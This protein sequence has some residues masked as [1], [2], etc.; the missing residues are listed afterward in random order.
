MSLLATTLVVEMPFDLF[1]QAVNVKA[2][3]QAIFKSERSW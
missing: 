1:L 2:Y 3:W